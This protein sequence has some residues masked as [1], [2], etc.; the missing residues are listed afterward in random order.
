MPYKVAILAVLDGFGLDALEV[1]TILTFSL[2]R[3]DLTP[4]KPHLACSTTNP[5]KPATNNQ[6][7]LEIICGS[8]PRETLFCSFFL[9][10]FFL[11]LSL[12]LNSCDKLCL[13]A[14]C[15][16]LRPPCE[17]DGSWG[18]HIFRDMI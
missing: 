1:I 13:M 12:S 4:S 9:L 14:L 18:L 2:S 10:S 5:W 16:Q 7:S 8:M 17:T 15:S 11:S 6:S 3:E